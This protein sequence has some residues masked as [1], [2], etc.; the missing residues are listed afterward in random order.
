MSAANKDAICIYNCNE[1]EIVY[2][3]EKQIDEKILFNTRPQFICDR[4]V[5]FTTGRIAITYDLK[6]KKEIR[7]VES[8]GYYSTFAC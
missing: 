3:Y 1:D 5:V 6:N 8:K 4:L 2:K 7:Q